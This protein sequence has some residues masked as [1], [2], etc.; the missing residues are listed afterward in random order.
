MADTN[1]LRISVLSWL[2]L[3]VSAGVLYSTA[4]V[5]YRLFLHPLSSHPGPLLARSTDLYQLW[6]SY[7]G[8]RHLEL[9]RLHQRYGPVVRIGPDSLSFNTSSS[10]K[11]IYGFKSNVRKAQFYDAFVHPAPNTHN[12]RDR[13][14]HARK[15]RV[16]AH[17]FSDGAI[18]EME[19]YILANIRTFCEGIGAGSRV[20]DNKGWTSPKCMSDW[21]SWLSMDILGDL[22]FGKAFHMLEKEDNR[23]AIDL[24]STAA[25]RH[26]ICGT[27]PILNTLSLD[28]LLFPNIAAGR[29]RY[30]AYSR[31]QLTE[32]T[33][34]GDETDRR[35][36]FYHLLKA[37]DPETGLGFSTPE[38]WGE[39]N[40]LI[41]AGSDT[42]S[43]ALAATLFYLVRSPDALRKVV[44]EIRQRF[45]DVEEIRQGAALNSCTYLRACIDEAMRMSPSVG[46]IV[47][48]EVL[49][50]GMTIDGVHV[51]E[52]TV[53]GVPHY[54]IHHNADYFP[55]PFRY[56]PERWI[57]GSKLPSST[58]SSGGVMVGETDVATAQGAFCP[59]SIGPRGCIGKGL[60]YVEMTM[61]LARTLWLY[62]VRRAEG[63]IDP[64]EGGKSGAEWGRDRRDEMQLVDTFT[65]WKEG[66]M[67]DFRRR[68][69]EET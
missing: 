61:T 22:C 26:L 48:R 67:V 15:R 31:A 54:A 51:P 21:F 47:P 55:E 27:M 56:V 39:S 43:T 53:V 60:A 68:E 18:K 66:V 64:A 7:R 59:F 24:V 10:L 9:W 16:M 33:K 32:R 36:F 46:G 50:G 6:H 40:L 62:D 23:F 45:T 14:L 20:G 28:R 42:T 35:D 8:D 3:F 11:E 29:A 34:L 38:L 41:I 30:M 69:E 19:R 2:G 25:H 52:G 5:L 57:A 12:C 4:V 13:Q 1:L 49:A 17:A 63:I 44:A 65:S 37:R 58:L